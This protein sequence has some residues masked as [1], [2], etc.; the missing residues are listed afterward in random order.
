MPLQSLGEITT[1]DR[2]HLAVSKDGTKLALINYNGL[3]E[4]FQFDRLTGIISHP[5]II[6]QEFSQGYKRYF[7]CEFSPNGNVLYASNADN[8]FGD[9]LRLNQYD[10]TSA[11]P[12]ITRQTIYLQQVPAGGGALKRG[13]DDRIYFSC[14]YEAGYP[15]LDSNRNV[16]NENLGVIVDPDVLGPSCT[17]L[18]FAIY[19]GGKRCYFGLPNNPNYDLGVL[20][21]GVPVVKPER[22]EM[23]ISPNPCTNYF[24]IQN[25][26]NKPITSNIN[27][28]N[29]L[30]Q[31][32][33][34]KNGVERNFDYVDVS[35]I[36]AG[37]YYI[38]LDGSPAES[39]RLIIIRP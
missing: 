26:N 4:T 3:I 14:I 12:A 18:P 23:L 34:I 2:S 35:D 10:L 17:F 9:T 1:T 28:R 22:N 30:G 36:D 8:T 20:N 24:T 7:G 6:S 5:S 31:I 32:V 38:T 37:V 29:S 25:T 11:F 16:Y 19:L 21:V 33:K 39:H 13:P 27:L 15:Y